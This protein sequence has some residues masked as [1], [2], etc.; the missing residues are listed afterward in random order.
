M[1]TI[2]C[3]HHEL[4]ILL[5]SVLMCC[6]VLAVTLLSSGLLALAV[7]KQFPTFRQILIRSSLGQSRFSFVI[8]TSNADVFPLLSINQLLHSCGEAPCSM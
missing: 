5:H 4:S 2:C 1:W 6:E 8:R 7:S 3:D